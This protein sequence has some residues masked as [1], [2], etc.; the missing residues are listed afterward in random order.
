MLRLAPASRSGV[1]TE[2]IKA[3]LTQPQLA[4]IGAVTL[5]WNEVEFM[6]DVS[7]YSGEDLP[8]DCLLDDLPRRR[9][10][11]KIKQLRKAALRWHLRSDCLDA[12]ESTAAAFSQL[13]DLRNAVVHSRLFNSQTGIGHR[14]TA[15]G[16]IYEV[17]LTTEALHWLYEQ[18][19]FLRSELRA[20]LAIFDL[21]RTTA[22]AERSGMVAVGQID[23]SG[24]VLSWL[25]EVD[26]CRRGRQHLGTAP[27][28]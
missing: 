8:A 12:I 20:L 2:N 5:A 13:K 16:E 1:T 4:G 21:V 9:L 10:D 23:P 28:F 14:V 17:L 3:D 22:A 24:E 18:L 19:V 25:S 7:L 15:R 11:E 6:L 27:E 26:R